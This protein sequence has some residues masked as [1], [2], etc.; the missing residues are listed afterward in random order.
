[1]GAERKH[2]LKITYEVDGEVIRVVKRSIT[3]REKWFLKG[4]SYWGRDLQ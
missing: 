3:E 1:M 4:N 2:K